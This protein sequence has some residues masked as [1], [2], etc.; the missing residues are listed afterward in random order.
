MGRR[1]VPLPKQ[2]VGVLCL[3]HLAPKCAFEASG[4]H[5]RLE[6]DGE[7]HFADGRTHVVFVCGLDSGGY[8]EPNA[9]RRGVLTR[10]VD[11]GRE[12]GPWA[13]RHAE[14]L[15]DIGLCRADDLNGLVVRGKQHTRYVERLPQRRE[16]VEESRW[17]AHRVAHDLGPRVARQHAERLR[18]GVGGDN[19]NAPGCQR[20]DDAQRIG[21]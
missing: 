6:D 18:V 8:G 17:V 12:V 19:R 15:A 13:P 16:I 14:P 9:P 2:C 3:Q 21:A 4:V 11:V 1:A 5:T 7:L 10:F 20:S